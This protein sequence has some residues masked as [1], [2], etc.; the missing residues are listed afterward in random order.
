MLETSGPGSFED[1][2]HGH[3]CLSSGGYGSLLCSPRVFTMKE[4]FIW[5]QL[6]GWRA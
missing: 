5:Q 3:W 4:I 6:E 2:V 1:L